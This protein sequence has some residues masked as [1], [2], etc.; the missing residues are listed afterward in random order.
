MHAFLSPKMVFKFNEWIVE[1]GRHT[2]HVNVGVCISEIRGR[3]ENNRYMS[4]P[5]YQI[6]YAGKKG[7]PRH[8]R[9]GRSS[10]QYPYGMGSL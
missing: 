5:L 8:R 10:V 7:T 2:M 1:Q 9:M 6:S 4:S 3:K